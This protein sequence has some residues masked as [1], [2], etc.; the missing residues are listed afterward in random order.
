M[1]MLQPW[2][3][4]VVLFGLVVCLAVVAIAF[5]AGRLSGKRK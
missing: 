1:G 3:I 5:A 4:A 2:H